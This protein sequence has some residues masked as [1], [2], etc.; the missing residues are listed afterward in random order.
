MVNSELKSR[1]SRW[2]RRKVDTVMA[3][4]K[5]VPK[6]AKPE[7]H[8]IW[9]QDNHCIAGNPIM[10]EPVDYDKDGRPFIYRCGC[11]NCGGPRFQGA[12]V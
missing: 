9:P 5:A 6:E 4:P 3:R 7:I 1:I 8:Y 11:P 2:F 10:Q 12:G